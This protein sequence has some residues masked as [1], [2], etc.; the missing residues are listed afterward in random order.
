MFIDKILQKRLV[1][2][3][4]FWVVLVGAITLLT[5]LNQG[6]FHQHLINNLALLPSQLMASYFLAYYQLPK[7]LYK[8]KY[9]RFIISTALAVFVFSVLARLSIIYFAEPLL[10]NDYE[11]E[12]LYEILSDP[13]Y[14][15]LVYVPAVYLL[16]MVM[17]LVKSIKDRFEERHQIEVLQ[18]EKATAELNFLKAQIHP[19]FLFNTLNNL[20]VLTLDKSDAA[21]EVVLKLAGILD[22]ILYQCTDPKV[23][24]EKEIQL[25]QHYIDL[26][27][28]RYG[29]K[30]DL[31]FDY[32]MDDPEVKIAPLLLLSLV[33]NAF[34]HGASG[35]PIDPVIHIKLRIA[36]NQLNFQVFNTKS[37][38]NNKNRSLKNGVGT[39]NLKRQLDLIYPD[40][41][42]LNVEEKDRSYL[43]VLKIKEIMQ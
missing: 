13:V 2:H 9:L 18:K 35:N 24:I 41:Y 25:I 23:S 16:P 32:R 6:T 17:I 10:R 33:E 40:K 5:S 1:S 29:D 27:T 12:T 36:D 14:L 4:L 7:L 22:Y 28:L 8:K 11:P 37:P 43:V 15:M 30:L 20:Y 21:P 26:E 42:E 31:V 38:V 39:G 3:I 19:H 34:K